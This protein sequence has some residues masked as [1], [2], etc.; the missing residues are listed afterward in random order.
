VTANFVPAETS[1][2]LPFDLPILSA[3]ETAAFRLKA[4][5]PVFAS[6]DI[7]LSPQQ[8]IDRLLFVIPYL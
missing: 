5:V 1:D 6:V 4:L 8:T 7:N 3:I 2:Y